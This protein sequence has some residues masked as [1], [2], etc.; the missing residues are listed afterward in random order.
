LRTLCRKAA[1]AKSH[2]DPSLPPASRANGIL[3]GLLAA[4]EGTIVSSA[5]ASEP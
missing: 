4:I 5:V 3:A 2:A 1:Q